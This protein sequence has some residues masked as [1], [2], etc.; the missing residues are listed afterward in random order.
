MERNFITY[1]QQVKYNLM[2]YSLYIP[3][4]L[5]MLIN[6]SDDIRAE[7]KK[8]V[9]SAQ[10]LLKWIYRGTFGTISFNYWAIFYNQC[11]GCFLFLCLL[12]SEKFYH[13]QASKSCV[14]WFSR[15]SVLI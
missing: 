11:V 1:T 8:I 3:I 9:Q 7:Y 10:R 12:I 14:I 5:I 13:T 2:D 15:I 6:Q 4:K